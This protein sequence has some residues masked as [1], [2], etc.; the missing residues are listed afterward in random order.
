M[1]VNPGEVAG[2][3][4]D[5]DGNGYVDDV[6]GWDFANNDNNPTDDN[7]HGT[8]VAGTIG[9]VGNNAVGV[10][11][12]NWNVK[13]MALKFLG[14]SGS[15]SLSGAIGA[16]DYA[17]RM[18]VKVSN[19]SWGGGG[20]NTALAAAIGRAQ[21]AGHIFVAAAGNSATNIDQTASYPASYIQTYNNVV[22]VAATDSSDQAGELLQLRRHLGDAGRAGGEHPQHHPGQHVQLLQRHVDG[23]AARG[24]GDRPVLGRQPHR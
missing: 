3:G 14:A 5:N 11:G 20:Y 6:R 18:G 15:G 4:L 10:A 24:R 2:D 23:R 12:V 19:N 21:A 17:V 22:N 9:A 8:H 13:I 7:G 16:L 1:W